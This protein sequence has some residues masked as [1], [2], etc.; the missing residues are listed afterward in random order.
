MFAKAH[1]SASH[2]ARRARIDQLDPGALERGNQF[3][4]RIDVGADHTIAGFHA[5]DGRHRKIGQLGHLPL[6]DAQKRARGSELIAGDHGGSLPVRKRI[7]L[8]HL[9][10]CLKHQFRGSAYH[11][12][13]LH[14]SLHDWHPIHDMINDVSHILFDAW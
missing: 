13:D 1:P 9:N 2:R 6:I 12:G 7:Y 11:P 5:L 3:H 10:Y 4:Q 8:S 14:R